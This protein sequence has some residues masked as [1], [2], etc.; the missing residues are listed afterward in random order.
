MRQSNEDSRRRLGVDSVSIH[1]KHLKKTSSGFS[2]H[3]RIS[4]S[5]K[6]ALKITVGRIK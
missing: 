1:K 6:K 3:N 5:V 4:T 2:T